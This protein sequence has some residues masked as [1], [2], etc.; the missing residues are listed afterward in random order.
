MYNGLEH[1]GTHAAM[2]NIVKV[3]PIAIGAAVA[4][5]HHPTRQ[6]RRPRSL[7]LRVSPVPPVVRSSFRPFETSST[8]RGCPPPPAD[9][10]IRPGAPSFPG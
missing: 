1:S 7:G 4:A 2:V 8:R 5:R 10:R 6:R 3:A 9:R